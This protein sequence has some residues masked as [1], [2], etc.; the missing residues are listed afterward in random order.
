MLVFG[1]MYRAASSLMNSPDWHSLCRRKSRRNKKHT[2]ALGEEG[3]LVRNAY[4]KFHAESAEQFVCEELVTNSP[5]SRL[6]NGVFCIPWGS[7]ALLDASD[8]GYSF[9][10]ESDLANAHPIWNFASPPSP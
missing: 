9:A 4:I 3:Q 1:L 8:I 5:V 2:V 6:S 10:S 7:L